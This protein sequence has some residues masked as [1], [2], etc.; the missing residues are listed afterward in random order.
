MN[1]AE[2]R[3][4]IADI[5]CSGCPKRPGWCECDEYRD[6]EANIACRKRKREQAD[7]IL[8]ICQPDTNLPLLTNKEIEAITLSD[9]PV[10]GKHSLERAVCQAER[11]KIKKYLDSLAA[12]AI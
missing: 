11:D 1:H 4:A 12:R 7:A 9:Y 2:K 5:L 3:E 8:K 10:R 6:F